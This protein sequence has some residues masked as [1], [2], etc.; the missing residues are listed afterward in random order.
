MTL[1]ADPAGLGTPD[2]PASA[3]DY[4]IVDTAPEPV[5]ND[6]VNVAAA[7]CEAPLA[8]L[9][10]INGTRQW[11]KAK[12]GF[13]ISQLPLARSA[14]RFTI[15]DRGLLV[16]R[17][18]SADARTRADT[19][20]TGEPG[21]RFY[22]GAPL[23]TAKGAIVG[24]LCVL[25]TSARPNGLNDTQLMVLETLARQAVAHLE[26]RRFTSDAAAPRRQGEFMSVKATGD[27]SATSTAG[28]FDIDIPT[29]IVTASE[30]MCQIFGLPVAQRYPAKVFEERVLPEDRGTESSDATRADG[31]A[32]TN[33]VYRIRMDDG[34]VKWIARNAVFEYDGSGKPVRMLGT[35]QDITHERKEAIR[36]EALIDLGDRLR[37]LDDIESMVIVASDLMSRTLDAIRAGFGIVDPVAET[38][39][40][41]SEW[42]APGAAS[43][44]GIHRFRDYGTYIEELKAGKTVTILDVSEDPRT[45][46]T[47]EAFLAL[48]VRS[49]VNLPIM[50]RGKLD[51]VVLVHHSRPYAWSED[52][53][54]FVRS[55]GDRVQVAIARL[56]AERDQD[57]LNREIGH[58][59][60]NTF[61][62]VQAIAQQTLRRVTERSLVTDFSR[63]LAALST[64]HDIL[65]SGEHEGAT[66]GEVVQGFARTLSVEDRVDAEGPD[67]TLGSRGTLSLSLLLHELGT[68][69]IKHGS[70]SNETGRVDVVWAVA[71]CGDSAEFR[72]RWR[73]SGG[74]PAHEPDQKGFGSKLISMGLI[75]TG[76]VETH[77][78]EE[79]FAAEM[80]A[81]LLQLERAN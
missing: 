79:G 18:L 24:T 15:E 19:L 14:C 31:S 2:G 65:L 12:L 78:G 34:A 75:G 59:L 45:R 55:F 66:V 74:P 3:V 77:Y 70:L 6:V 11:F 39:V 23:I 50:D 71:G 36:K 64:A 60:K 58:R 46:D 20:V 37:D 22:A 25:D 33:V 43:V 8:F 63:R 5:F 80:T 73:E 72:L 16:I 9:S 69:A 26:A 76:G 42:R 52:E 30:S 1:A 81:N 32:P 41:R 61:A 53:L 13:G 51:L 44:A 47:A 21:L 68:N 28:V 10:F 27:G 54:A 7:V 35:V 56:Q 67:V 29:G 4:G 49:L 38:V 62:M 57:L 40:V 17:D 48:G